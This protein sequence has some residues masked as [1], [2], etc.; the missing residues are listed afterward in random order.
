MRRR[1]R[2]PLVPGWGKARNVPGWFSEEEA[3]LLSTLCTGLWC[4]I[5]SY[6]GRSTIV[7]AATGHEGY[8]IDTHKGSPEMKRK[9]SWEEFEWNMAPYENVITVRAKFQSRH[10]VN[11]VKD[12]LMLLHLDADH[13]YELTKLAFELYSPK[14]LRGGHVCFHDA[15]GGAWP[16]VEQVVGELDPS[17]WK[18]VALVGQL[19][20]FQRLSE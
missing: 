18:R 17:E 13:S 5:G 10:T 7:L 16:G 15:A 2:K 19:A 11:L 3:R 14:V 4:E 9:D 12:E 6:L 1:A 8:S 20:A